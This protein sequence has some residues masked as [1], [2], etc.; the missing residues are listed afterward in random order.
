MFHVKQHTYK[1]LL[2]NVD[3]FRELRNKIRRG[4]TIVPETSGG[5]I[6]DIDTDPDN[7]DL[8]IT[9]QHVNGQHAH[10]IVIKDETA[11]APRPLPDSITP[12]ED[13]PVEVVTA[14][15]AAIHEAWQE[16][17]GDPKDAAKF[18]ACLIGA[19]S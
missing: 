15:Q 11:G 12:P 19:A 1:E 8:L 4:L 7:N 18:F 14:L 2:V 17:D 13:M 6:L 5:Q 9:W 16:Y 10:R 3:A